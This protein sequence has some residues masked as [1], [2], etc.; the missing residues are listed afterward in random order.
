MQITNQNYEVYSQNY[1][2]NYYIVDKMTKNSYVQANK[3]NFKYLFVTICKNGGLI[4]VCKT[5]SFFDPAKSSR[6]NKNVIVMFQN[7]KTKYEVPIDWD[8][9]KRWLV[10][11]DFSENENLYGICNDG[12]I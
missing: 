7:S 12:A 1:S 2:E 11:F 6:L 3:L 5:K 10:G 9:S 4:A 8:Y